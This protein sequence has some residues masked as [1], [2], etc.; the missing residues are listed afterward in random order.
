MD[1]EADL[2][3]RALENWRRLRL[4]VP[5]QVLESD[6]R[7]YSILL[8]TC[9]SS[10]NSV[11]P[12][13]TL[14]DG[15]RA[16]RIRGVQLPS[17]TE[18]RALLARLARTC[19]S[20]SPKRLLAQLQRVG[21]GRFGEFEHIVRLPGDAVARDIR[22]EELANGAFCVVVPR[23]APPSMPPK[24]PSPPAPPPDFAAMMAISAGSSA[25]APPPPPTVDAPADCPVT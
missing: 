15:G 1:P 3:C 13:C 23:A 12:Q 2:V 14:V 24:A 18:A 25:D 22:V 5:A 21:E 8:E 20:A 9:G 17:T 11:P 19:L 7:H 16:L 10:E 4:R 6:S